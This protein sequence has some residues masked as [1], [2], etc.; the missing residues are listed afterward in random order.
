VELTVLGS[1]TLAPSALRTAP[2]HWVRAGSVNLLLDC[3]AGTLHR[4][5]TFGVPWSDVT[6]IAI[7]HFH[8]DHWSEL[9]L[10]L[11]ALR[12][13]VEPPR[14][15]P[16][17]LIGPVGLRERL[18]WLARAYGDWVLEPEFPLEITE[19]APGEDR[20]LAPGIKLES[21]STPHT[22]ESLAYAV[23]SPEGRMVYTGDTG[24]SD[25][26]ARWATDCDLLLAECSLPDAR[27]I[28]LHLTP[29]TAGALARQAG[30]GTL[31][32]T[33]FYPV[34]GDTDPGATAAE[35]F[36]GEVIVAQDGSRFTIGN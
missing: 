16:V 13:G 2:A 5:A 34:F 25:A 27:A 15:D 1:G 20:E 10:F 35:Q 12:W 19:V 30:A 3:G 7:T 4:A 36:S 24:P 17:N 22:D 26:L 9:P 21:C 8:P 32:L 31:V 28:E 6:H 14:T 18:G 29:T 33:H 23:R 11:F